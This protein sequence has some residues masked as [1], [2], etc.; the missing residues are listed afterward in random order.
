LN[1]LRPH[2][3]PVADGSLLVEYPD[4]SD[5]DANR[6]A[7]GLA[8]ILASR[9]RDGFLDAIPGA[10][11]VFCAFDPRRVTHEAL[12]GEI[13]AARGEPSAARG[14]REHLVPVL[15]GGEAGADLPELSRRSGISPEELVRLHA[16]ATYRVAFLGFQPG[17][18]YMTGLPAELAAPRLSTPR[19][20]VAA[21]SLAVAGSYAGIYPS[22]GPG[23]WNLVGR[24]A[25][26]LFDG[27]RNPPAL[28]SP[29]DLVR[30]SPQ[31][32]EEFA[33]SLAGLPAATPAAVPE[34]E[35]FLRVLSP[36][37]WCAPCGEP[38][39][40]LGSSGVPPSGAMDGR[41][42]AAGNALL[43]NRPSDA[44]LE[45]VV[46]GPELEAL[47]DGV[48]AFSGA[49]CEASAGG[50]ALAPATPARIR[51]G[52][53]ILMGAIRYGVRAYL[54]V[55][56]GLSLPTAPG[57]PARM[58]P[59]DLLW[60]Q[61]GASP[62]PDPKRVATAAAF[63][64]PSGEPVVRIVLGPQETRFREEGVARLLGSAYRVSSTSD[65]RGVRLEGPRLEASGG[66]EIAPEGT[67]LG[68]IQVPADGQPIVLGPDRPVTGGY[69]KIATVIA[70]D[71]P[72]VAQARPGSFLRFSAVS[73]AAAV[74]ARGR[75]EWP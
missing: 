33:R 11:T 28:F 1:G 55:E 64:Q 45:I 10:R 63:A 3:R 53:R 59:G 30:F 21:G 41:S 42:L 26:L 9:G 62:R 75:M 25:A 8:S 19:P 54:C 47:A 52:E 44:G 73:R 31:G 57:P 56:G 6:A 48:V 20:R 50:R 74:E 22:D 15:Y 13:E 69:V 18:A 66:A 12:S 68:A 72:I 23:G 2:V 60:R 17:F 39:H 70:A 49:P 40:G 32:E 51:K 37:L 27:G 24:A 7:V 34:G 38:R 71:F 16:G 67:A 35:P 65:R 36:G 4:A 5:E 43:G 61:I 46:A 14:P 29:G 58:R